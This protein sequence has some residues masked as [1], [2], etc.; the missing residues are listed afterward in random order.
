MA[1]VWPW[2]HTAWFQPYV[3]GYYAWV[4]LGQDLTRDEVDSRLGDL[5][6][7][8]RRGTLLDEVD[9]DEEAT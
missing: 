8:E 5:L 4:Y 9:P 6:A 7:L 1:R 3:A 2:E